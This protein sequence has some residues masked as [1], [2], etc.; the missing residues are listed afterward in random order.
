MTPKLHLSTLCYVCQRISLGGKASACNICDIQTVKWGGGDCYARSITYS[1]VC[2]LCQERGDK[3]VYI[4]ESSL[5]LYE[6]ANCPRNEGERGFDKSH[7]HQHLSEDHPDYKGRV[8]DAFWY[9]Q[10]ML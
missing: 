8:R 2:L 3:S 1:N 5:S 4:G 7:I 6:R 10:V 9:T